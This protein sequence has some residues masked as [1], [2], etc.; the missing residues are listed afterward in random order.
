[1]KQEYKRPYKLE[2]SH[3]EVEIGKLLYELYG[4]NTPSGHPNWEETHTMTK[5]RWCRQA[6]ALIYLLQE[7]GWMIK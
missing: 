5:N 1:M 2:F 7:E 4:G 3:I 6:K